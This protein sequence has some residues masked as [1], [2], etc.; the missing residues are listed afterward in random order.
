MTISNNEISNNS[1]NNFLIKINFFSS[2]K[3][4]KP[5]IAKITSNINNVN[6]SNN[7]NIITYTNTKT[8]IIESKPLYEKINLY[9]NNK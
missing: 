6:T 2:G 3:T 4:E 8:N 9:N 7:N 1:K 5:K